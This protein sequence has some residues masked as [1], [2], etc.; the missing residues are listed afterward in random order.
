VDIAITSTE[1]DLDIK[2]DSS[3]SIDSVTDTPINIEIDNF[4][5]FNA[6]DF[7]NMFSAKTTDDLAEGDDNLYF[8][9][10]RVKSAMS[11]FY[12]VPLTFGTG[13]TRTG[14]TITND[15]TQYTD[16]DAISAIQGDASWNAPD[17]DTAYGW[18]DHSGLYDDIGTAS[19]LIETHESTYDH[20]LIATA[21]QTETDPVFSQWESTTD[22][23]VS[24]DNVSELENDAGYLTEHQ[25]L[26]TINSQSLLGTGNINTPDTTYTA[27]TGLSL[28][29]T[30]FRNTDKGSDVD[31]SGYA[32]ST[33][34]LKLDQT[35]PQTVTG[36]PTF[37]VLR[38]PK[39]YPSAD[40]TTAVGIFKADGTT[41]VLNVDTTNGNVGIGTTSPTEKLEID[42]NLFLNGDN[43]KILLGA[44][45]D[46]SISYDGTNMVF[47]SQE[48]GAGDFVFENGNVGIGTTSPQVKTHIYGTAE[49]TGTDWKNT[50]LSISL[51]VTDKD[52]GIE[53]VSS[54]AG[55]WGSA[56]QFK[57]V[58]GG[59]FE[60]TWQIV[61]QTN[62]DGAGDGSL[63]FGYGTSVL[64]DSNI[65]L[66]TFLST[67]NVG[68]GT[69]APTE[70]LEIDGNL[71]LNGDNDKIY[72]GEDKD[73]YIEYDPTLDGIQTAGKF[74]A[75]EVRAIH[76]A[77]DGT[78]P[79]AD[80]TY[81]M[82]IGTATNGTI[83]I[84]DGIITAVTECTNA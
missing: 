18:G 49:A 67:G 50:Q 76:K 16:S 9:D 83:T 2:S 13:L 33:D 1:I 62:G 11:G 77:V 45:K 3:I 5:G 82:G 41:N 80:G 48:V 66:V 6:T 63:R 56:L 37:P 20:D 54:D 47:D 73:E 23:L 28:V 51:A 38:T 69:T 24:S 26:K 72:F 65:S 32:L 31:L 25:D 21:L 14:N 27:G 42:G 84:V 7:N 61:R 8:T 39:I 58:D 35:T 10:E 81:V 19:G 30:E 64:T 60:N 52:A 36:T 71:F 55:T 79:V 15:I 44:G 46:A 53:L 75:S 34:V 78:A 40:S 22:Y 17:W 74:K 12:E 29:G 59:T 68:I 57:Q 70:K 4:A 43:D